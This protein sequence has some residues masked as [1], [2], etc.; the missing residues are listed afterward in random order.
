[1]WLSPT[2]QVTRKKPVVT[3]LILEAWGSESCASSSFHL[4]NRIPHIGNSPPASSGPAD[5]CISVCTWT[6]VFPNRYASI[7]K[8]EV[9]TLMSRDS[10]NSRHY[11]GVAQECV[12]EMWSKTSVHNIEINLGNPRRSSAQER[13][14]FQPLR[15]TK[16]DTQTHYWSY[17]CSS[18]AS[19]GSNLERPIGYR[20]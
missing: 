19:I 8:S 6:L 9:K 2:G 11:N 16:K 4:F 17:L 7:W 12:T 18:K 10:H 13:L 5:T 20:H 1:M 15:K 3:S 14:T